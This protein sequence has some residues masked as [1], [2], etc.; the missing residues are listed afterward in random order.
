MFMRPDRFFFQLKEK[1]FGP[2]EEWPTSVSWW[3]GTTIRS[4]WTVQP[5]TKIHPTLGNS[6][7][8]HLGVSGQSSA[9]IA[10]LLMPSREPE[11]PMGNLHSPLV[12]PS[13]ATVAGRERIADVD[14][15]RIDGTHASGTPR[16]LW[17]DARDTLLRQIGSSLVFDEAA[18]GRVQEGIR[19]ELAKLPQSAPQRATLQKALEHHETVKSPEFTSHTTILFRPVANPTLVPEA[20]EFTA[21]TA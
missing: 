11:S 19:A 8:A 4:W 1:S 16:S 15:W 6:L 2:E 18:R 10:R 17:I 12:E 13:T 9:A 14:C 20:F 3:D 21:P 5:V 7:A